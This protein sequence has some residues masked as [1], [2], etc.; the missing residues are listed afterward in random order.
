MDLI[1]SALDPENWENL[2]LGQDQTNNE[3]LEPFRNKGSELYLSTFF[4]FGGWFWLV[5]IFSGLRGMLPLS[6][7]LPCGGVPTWD[8]VPWIINIFSP[9][10]KTETGTW[11]WTWE[12]SENWIKFS[13][14]NFDWSTNQNYFLKIS[15]IWTS[16][17]KL[18]FPVWTTTLLSNRWLDGWERRW[19]GE[20]CGGGDEFEEF[21]D[22]QWYGLEFELLKGRS[23]PD[24]KK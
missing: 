24:Y 4:F 19:W 18:P 6:L 17:P 13:K 22:E 16:S 10:L 7:P 3:N 23:Y 14:S 8:G 12:L 21:G 9:F 20:Y 2:G 1:R 15:W 5:E 11:F